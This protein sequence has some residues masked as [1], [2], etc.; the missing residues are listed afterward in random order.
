MNLALF[1]FDETEPKVLMCWRQKTEIEPQKR[2]VE[3]P[4]KK[5]MRRFVVLRVLMFGAHCD[6]S[7]LRQAWIN[8]IL[9]NPLKKMTRWDCH[10]PEGWCLSL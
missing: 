10:G 6:N 5:S 4:A 8:H 9:A 1:V 2:H 3:P 7:S